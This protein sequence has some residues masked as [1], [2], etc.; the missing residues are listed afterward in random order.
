VIKKFILGILLVASLTACPIVDPPIEPTPKSPIAKDDVTTTNPSTAATIKPA[1]NDVKGDAELVIS[2]IDLDTSKS[3][4]QTSYTDSTGKGSFQ[5]N[6]SSG[7]VTFTP[8]A[9]KTGDAT[10]R[11]TIKDSNGVISSAATIKVT[12]NS[13]V[14]T[15]PLKVLFIGNSRTWYEPCSGTPS[16]FL[17]YNIPTML[18]NMSINETRPLQATEVT[19][20][21]FSLDQHWN[22]VGDAKAPVATKG[23]DYV[24]LQAAT[25]ETDPANQSNTQSLLA[26]YKTAI[27]AA[28]PNAKIVLSENWSLQCSLSVTSLCGPS[29]QSRLTTFYQTT[30][31]ILST[32]KI[33]PIGRAWRLGGLT[34]TQMFIPDGEITSNDGGEKQL[35]HATPLGAYIAASTYYSL[36]YGKQAPNATGVPSVPSG[37]PQ[38]QFSSTEANTAR[39]NAYNA[40]SSM[41]IKYK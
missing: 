10:A 25:F 8:T 15:G 23:W 7:I 20:C 13:T 6:N 21:G 30:A 34:E 39:T 3:G 1:D 37:Y 36:F 28:N 32:T 29:D 5:L 2:S 24:V 19:D 41:N 12:I 4:Q 26:Q 14:I 22:S 16:Q 40:Y 11:Y 18:Q 31:D 33:A 9:G 27:L 35:K 38:Y 17:A